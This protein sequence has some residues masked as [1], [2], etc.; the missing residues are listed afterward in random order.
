[1]FNAVMTM[2]TA[3]EPDAELAGRLADDLDGAFA[4]LVEVHG[5]MAYRLALRTLNSPPDAEEVAQ[6]ALVR[7]YQA[8]RDYPPERVRDL[9]LRGWL[10]TVVLNAARNRA[11]SM[12][13]RPSAP[14]SALPAD[15]VER[16]A[17][18]ARAAEVA[19]ETRGWAER[20]AALPERQ[21]V[22]I[23]LRHVEDWSYADIADALGRP[24]GTVKAQ[25][26][27]GLAALRA[28]LEV[29]P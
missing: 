6:E 9:R 3:L 8:L 15:P 25:V 12:A 18:P 17:G 28:T 21:R 2:T 14:L 26:S 1:V 29:Q 11:R 13:R 24:V 7:A 19:D 16:D 20:L 23:V 10:A 5:G 27:R 4:A 22:P